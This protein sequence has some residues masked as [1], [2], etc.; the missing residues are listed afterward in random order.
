MVIGEAY[1]KAAQDP[2]VLKFCAPSK[3]DVCI[4]Q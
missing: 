4:S 3:S 1:R 2:E